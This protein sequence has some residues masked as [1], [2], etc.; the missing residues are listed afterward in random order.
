MMLHT[1]HLPMRIGAIAAALL[2]TPALGFCQSTDQKDTRPPA[3]RDRPQNTQRPQAQQDHQQDRQQN[4][5]QD[6]PPVQR[7][8]APPRPAQPQVYQQPQVQRP[9]DRPAQPQPQTNPPGRQYGN[10]PQQQ[11]NGRRFGRQPDT[12]QSQQ[13]PN[14]QWNQQQQPAGRPYGTPPGQDRHD[15]TNRPAGQPDRTYTPRQGVR[16]ETAPGNR[17]VY[18]SPNG[19]QVQM[20]HGRVVEVHTHDGA[21]IHHGPEGYRTVEMA[22]PGGRTVVVNNYGGGYVQ[23]TVVI[24][25]TSYVQRTYVYNGV[26]TTRVYRPY[27]YRPGFVINV[28]APVHYYHPGLYSWAYNPWARPV[29][30]ASWG[31]AGTP[32]YGYYGGYFSP[33][34]YYSS[35]A[36]WLTDYMIAATLEDAYQQRMA[37][38]ME[39]V[40]GYYSGEPGLTPDVKQ[41]IADEVAFQVHEEQGEAQMG[42]VQG[43]AN[44]FHGGRQIFVADTTVEGLLSDR[45]CAITAGDVLEMRGMPPMDAVT[46]PVVVRAGKRGGCPRGAVVVVGLQDLA[47]MH[48][49]MREMVDRGLGDLQRRQG[50][51]GLPPMNA[52]AV[53]PPTPVSWASQVQPD[54]GAQNE[55]TQVANDASRAEQETVDATVQ[56]PPADVAPSAEPVAPPPSGRTGSDTNIRI[57]STIEDV[58]GAW[59]QPDKIADLGDKKIYVYQYVKVTFQDG[60]VVDVQ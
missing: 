49:R 7:Q 20:D 57:G 11:D 31:W 33:A 29:Y 19:G 36:L 45:A 8:E 47:E 38:R 3:H 14:R 48:N 23:R 56:A 13:Q 27:V 28:Y 58:V 4:R 42:G 26:V 15:I 40:P 59:G 30:Y 34:P 24:R 12:P 60:K 44:P 18:H 21:V 10:Q 32:W 46:T 22:R 1:P 16:M 6:R 53:A 51:G 9:P 17:Q 55:L 5:Q 35:P 2:L 37:A 52:E 25:N 39:M 50:Q 41:A 43:N 54:S